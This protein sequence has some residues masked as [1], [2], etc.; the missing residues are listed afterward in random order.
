MIGLRR[1]LWKPGE[2]I[3][4]VGERRGRGKSSTIGEQPTVV[5]GGGYLPGSTL[6]KD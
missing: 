2:T 3:S 1:I 5:P 6:G 4:D